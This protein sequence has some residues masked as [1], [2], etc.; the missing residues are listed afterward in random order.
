MKLFSNSLVSNVRILA[1]IL[2]I[3]I[4]ILLGVAFKTTQ[5]YSK[6][7][8]GVIA[9]KLL[10]IIQNNKTELYTF[11]KDKD[12]KQVDK[13]STI[14]MRKDLE[15]F[16]SDDDIRDISAKMGIKIYLI[17]SRVVF[18]ISVNG[19]TYYFYSNKT[20]YSDVVLYFVLY[21]F[22]LLLFLSLIY[23]FVKNSLK[24]LK[25]LNKN[26][27]AFSN[28]KEV[29]V[30]YEKQSDEISKLANAFYRA[31]ENSI[32]I[33]KQKDIFTKAIMHE[34][35]TPLTKAKFLTHFMSDEDKNKDRFN[36][37][38]DQMS[39]EMLRLGE[40]DKISYKMQKLELKKYNLKSM[41]DEV[42]EALM[43]DENSY[44]VEYDNFLVSLDYTLFIMLVKNLIDNALKY[45]Q[46]NKIK[47]IIDKNYI[48]F[49]NKAKDKAL[50]IDIVK[51]AYFGEFS[52]HNSY[53]LGLYLVDEIVNIHNFTLEYSFKDKLH[54]F[55]VCF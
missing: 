38:F 36:N 7:E 45:S 43:I 23:I 41:L 33:K 25:K 5:L 52:T 53:G 18:D 32:K 44:E 3:L 27:E 10:N 55:K 28:N 14:F 49:Q 30:E 17:N 13:N 54:I 6:K 4:S 50:D 8:Q 47:I 40:L 19:A 15:D 34:L 16:I 48:S 26:I 21:L 46:D 9:I 42:L 11:L 12:L 39:K 35:K 29:K 2:A 1:F 31:Y 22:L 37:L 24:P 20:L 51:N